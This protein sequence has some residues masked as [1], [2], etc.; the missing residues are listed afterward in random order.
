MLRNDNL[1]EPNESVIYHY[2]EDFPQMSPFMKPV[3]P[4]AAAFFSTLSSRE[5]NSMWFSARSKKTG[6][7]ATG[8][9][10]GGTGARV[11]FWV[12]GV[13]RN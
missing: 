8:Q 2:E 10:S 1:I 12:G 9:Y 13:N 3:S 5:G 4:P 7:Q 6:L 11:T